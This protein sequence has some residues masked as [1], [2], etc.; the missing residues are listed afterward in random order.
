MDSILE[1][2]RSTGDYLT[3]ASFDRAC[4]IVS[5]NE[6]I[7]TAA[8]QRAYAALEVR[9]RA[10]SLVCVWLGGGGNQ[11]ATMEDLRLAAIDCCWLGLKQWP[12][13]LAT[14][15][16]DSHAFHLFFLAC[17]FVCL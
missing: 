14:T 5:Q 3:Q 2:M 17:V 6:A 9:L 13:I 1:A 11:L 4:L 10:R 8:A 15:S 16:G 7:G 12:L